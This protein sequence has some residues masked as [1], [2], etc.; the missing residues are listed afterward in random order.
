MFLISSAVNAREV[1][2][3]E[4][5]FRGIVPGETQLSEIIRVHGAPR[6]KQSNSNNVKYFFRGFDVTIQDKTGKT[7]TI[8]VYDNKYVDKNGINVGTSKKSV[9]ITLKQMTE[10]NYLVDKINGII[11]WFEKSEVEKIVL[12]YSVLK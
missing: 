3:F 6:G 9:M 12:V 5:S 7:N 1:L 2:F 10:K 4:N 8:L 11:Y